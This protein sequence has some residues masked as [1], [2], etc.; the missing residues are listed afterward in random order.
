MTSVSVVTAEALRSNIASGNSGE[1]V[2]RVTIQ[3]GYHVN[4][5]PPT[6]R[7]LKATELE[8]SPNDGVSVKSVYY[9]PPQ[10]KKFAFAEKPLAVYEGTTELKAT[11]QADRSATKGGRSLTARL[12]IQ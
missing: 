4:A 8:M 6:Y 9:P 12:R 11:L 1:V 10:N 3:N 5:N 7:Y 2:V